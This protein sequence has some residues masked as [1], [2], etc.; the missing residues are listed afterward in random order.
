MNDPKYFIKVIVQKQL[1]ELMSMELM[2]NDIENCKSQRDK[3]IQEMR[4]LAQNTFDAVA[5]KGEKND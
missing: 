4:E 2:V 5:T 1:S 3:N